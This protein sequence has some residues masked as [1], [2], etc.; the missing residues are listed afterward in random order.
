MRLNAYRAKPKVKM[1]GTGPYYLGVELEVE[2][3]NY[4]THGQGLAFNKNPRYYHAKQDGSLVNGWEIVTHPIGRD[5][6][7]RK[8]NKP[9]YGE[10]PVGALIRLVRGLT[11]LGYRSHDSGRCGLHVHVCRK[12]FTAEGDVTLSL[13]TDH[14]F[15]FHKLVNG[16][17]FR[18]LSQRNEDG[19]RYCRQIT[20]NPDTFGNNYDAHGRYVAV[21]KTA[22]TVEVRIFRGNLRE[23]RIR[24]AVEAVIAAVEFTKELAAAGHGVT[25]EADVDR[26]Y[27]AWVAEHQ[28]TYKNLYQYMVEIGCYQPEAV[29]AVS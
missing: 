14:F 3:P 27:V 9:K 19:M 17:L 18:G 24:K 11:Q 22:K 23:D 6:W 25:N 20:T 12:A 8:L 26:L 10:G 29:V 2:A 4:Q 5:E 28:T 13:K 7:L 15:L 16:P 1:Q 21:N